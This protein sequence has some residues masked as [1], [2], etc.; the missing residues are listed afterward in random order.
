M[1]PETALARHQASHQTHETR[2][3]CGLSIDTLTHGC[4]WCGT[5]FNDGYRCT[6][7]DLEPSM[8]YTESVCLLVLMIPAPHEAV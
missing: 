5:D 6:Q 8:A 7:S 4:G 3:K 1:R 2:R